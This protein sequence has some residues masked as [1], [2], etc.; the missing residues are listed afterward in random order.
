MSK[1]RAFQNEV[2]TRENTPSFFDLQL[3][4]LVEENH[5]SASR[6]CTLIARCFTLGR[7]GP[8]VVVDEAADKSKIEGIIVM[9]T[10]V[11][12]PPEVDG[13]GG[14][15]NRQGKPATECWYY[16]KKGHW[17]RECWKKRAN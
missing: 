2:C 16:A 1:F 4:L 3:M 12:H 10:V 11:P 7:I 9:Q 17:E 5:A 6:V 13:E 15:E 14:A 8:V